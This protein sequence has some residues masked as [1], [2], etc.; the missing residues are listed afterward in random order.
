MSERSITIRLSSETAKLY[1]EYRKKWISEQVPDSLIFR[2][3]LAFLMFMPEAASSDYMDKLIKERD[4]IVE[5][6]KER[7]QKNPDP[8]LYKLWE[9]YKANSD[10]IE[11]AF[12]KLAEKY[13]RIVG[14]SKR[15]RK[16]DPNKK[17]T[18]GRPSESEKEYNS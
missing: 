15:G 3:G 13:V 5:E 12:E 2:N 10:Q 17:H 7:F 11:A 9:K 14:D 6:T 8:Q 18:P 4:Q 16:P 1:D